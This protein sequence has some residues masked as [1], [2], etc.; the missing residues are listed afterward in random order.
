MNKEEVK[1]EETS[2]VQETEE[3]PKGY[4]DYDEWVASGKDPE[5][6][7]D[8][9]E[10]KRKGEEFLPFVQKERDQLRDQVGK[11]QNDVQTIIDQ[12]KQLTESRA[13]EAYEKAKKE[14]DSKLEQIKEAKYK[15]IEDMDG[16]AL[17][18]AESAEERLKQHE[19]EPPKS[20]PEP[21]T[22]TQKFSPDFEAWQAENPWFKTEPKTPAETAMHTYAVEA[23]KS[24]AASNPG[25]TERQLYDKVSEAVQQEF[26]HKF[27]NPRKYEGVAGVEGGAPAKGKGKKTYKDL[28]R[29]AKEAINGLLSRNPKVDKE[30]LVAG[31]LNEY[32][33]EG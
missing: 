24:I 28:P 9:E 12:Q 7:R 4:M 30:R 26:P 8:I 33:P 1:T 32:F 23:S 14:F 17:R 22:R 27:Q 13:K 20:E 5:Q 6:W 25:L 11:L 31:Y 29:E 15:A 2:P 19:P 21:K 18:D 10:W 16:Q 3:K